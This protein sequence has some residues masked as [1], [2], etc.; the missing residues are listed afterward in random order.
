MTTLCGFHHVKLP[1]SDVAT[2]REWYE[3]C[4]GSR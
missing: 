1:V 3:R 4:S 2:S